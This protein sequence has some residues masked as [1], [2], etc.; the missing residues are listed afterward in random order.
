MFFKQYEVPVNEF[1]WTCPPP[2]KGGGIPI[3][4]GAYHVVIHDIACSNSCAACGTVS[5][6]DSTINANVAQP[7][8]DYLVNTD[9]YHC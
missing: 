8:S 9:W 1:V 7:S 5:C 4:Y 3:C 6:H 2:V